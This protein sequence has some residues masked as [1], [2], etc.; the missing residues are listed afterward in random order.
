MIQY[1]A[2]AIPEGGLHAM[3]R[4]YADGLCSIGDTGGFLNGM[5]LKGIHLAIKSGMLA[6]E[7]IFEALARTIRSDA[8][9]L[10]VVR[11][12][13]PRLVGV[14]RTARCAQFPCR[15]QERPLRRA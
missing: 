4:F 15:F 10:A 13:V 2:K 12:E 11:A 14:H 1:G 5:R 6:A 8:G 3:P 9:A 7:A